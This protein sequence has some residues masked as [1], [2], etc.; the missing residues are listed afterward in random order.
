[1]TGVPVISGSMRR[2]K[3]K[4]GHEYKALAPAQFNFGPVLSGPMCPLCL[5]QWIG[6][7]FAVEEVKDEH[8]LILEP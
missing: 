3:C 5:A 1:M 4:K 7:E 6:T 8:S 2:F